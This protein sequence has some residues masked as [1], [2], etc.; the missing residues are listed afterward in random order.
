MASTGYKKI[1]KHTHINARADGRILE[2]VYVMSEMLGRAL[3]PLEV[4][5]HKDSNPQNNMPGNLQ[6]FASQA[7]HLVHHAKE[8]A[9]A[10]C[11]NASFM[12]C[13]FCKEYD[14]P[15]NM[16]VRDKGYK[17]YHNSCNTQYLQHYRAKRKLSQQSIGI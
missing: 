15:V 16:H 9:L 3:T 11:G 7:E 2:H 6:L 12:K 5:H 8:R 13:P 1:V 14:N 17:A 4:V 10:E